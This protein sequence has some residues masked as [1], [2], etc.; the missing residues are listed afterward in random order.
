MGCGASHASKRDEL[1]EKHDERPSVQGSQGDSADLQQE[2]TSKEGEQTVVS[3]TDEGRGEVLGTH[4]S[5]S[6]LG[7]SLGFL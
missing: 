4:K 3:E 5:T 6:E 2:L 1:D 7:V